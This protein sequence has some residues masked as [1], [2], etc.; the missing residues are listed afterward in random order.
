MLARERLSDRKLSDRLTSL[1]LSLECPFPVSDNFSDK[2]MKG[3]LERPKDR[4]FCQTR[5]LWHNN[6][7]LAR[8]YTIYTPTVQFGPFSF[9]CR[10]RGL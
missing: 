1:S 2:S 6:S 3:L 8:L 4:S 5:T 7:C 10:Y 9:S